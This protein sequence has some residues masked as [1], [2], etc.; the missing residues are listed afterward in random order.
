M[1][2]LVCIIVLVLLIIG[3]A[4]EARGATAPPLPDPAPQ[5]CML[6]WCPL[7]RKPRPWWT[8]PIPLKGKPGMWR[9]YMDGKPRT[10]CVRVK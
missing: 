2:R 1:T 6:N 5:A 4:D 9:C 7:P 3:L 8:D 10:L